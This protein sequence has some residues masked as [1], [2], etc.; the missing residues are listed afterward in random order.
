M[1][2]EKK[3]QSEEETLNL[4]RKRIKDSKNGGN[5]PELARKELLND[6]LL[7]RK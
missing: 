7:K 5:L 2:F 3:P 1:K 6:S 4:L